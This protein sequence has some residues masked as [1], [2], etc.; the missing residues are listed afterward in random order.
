LWLGILSFA[1]P[2][3]GLAGDAFY[4][5]PCQRRCIWHTDGA[6]ANA[7]KKDYIRVQFA[8]G[9]A[10]L[11]LRNPDYNTSDISA[12]RFD[13]VVRFLVCPPERSPA[14]AGGVEGQSLFAGALV[15]PLCPL[16]LL[17]LGAWSLELGAWSLQLGA[18]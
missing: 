15:N 2:T 1:V 17:F 12:K 10:N 3:P 4:D 6:I 18:D 8:S 14:A 13:R 11:A 7:L 5:C 16:W 9:T